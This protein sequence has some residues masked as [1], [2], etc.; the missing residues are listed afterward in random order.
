ME[1]MT[2]NRTQSQARHAPINGKIPPQ[3]VWDQVWAKDIYA[4]PSIRRR[5]SKQKVS[6]I[7]DQGFSISDEQ[8]LLEVGCGGGAVLE[9]IASCCP[10]RGYLIG[11]DISRVAL[12]LARENLTAI[13]ATPL[14]LWTDAEKLP[15][16]RE[17][18]DIIIA[19]GILEHLSQPMT[20]LA[21]MSRILKPSGQVYFSTSSV[22]SSVYVARRIREYLSNWPYGYQK[23]YRPIE[24]IEL[25][26]SFFHVTQVTVAQTG[27]DFPLLATA[28]RLVAIVSREWGRYILVAAEKA[29]AE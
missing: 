6:I 9:E 25:I 26:G 4:D 12:K 7:T 27:F 17:S 24:F 22:Y 11:C 28:D 29:E 21:E 13:Q 15:F 18:I 5:R 3:L 10:D 23:N 1:R 2:A 19:F 14:L 20:A 8:H 16:E